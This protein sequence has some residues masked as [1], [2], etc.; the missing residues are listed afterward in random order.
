MLVE[1]VDITENSE[2]KIEKAARLCYDSKEN[3]SV[4]AGFIQRLIN[5]GHL[6]VIEHAKATFL[7]TGVSRAFSH[8]LVRHRIASYSQRSQRFCDESNINADH[9]VPDSILNNDLAR[10]EYTNLT[11]LSRNTYRRLVSL[12]IPKEDARFV[13]TNGTTTKIMITM[14][15]RTLREFIQKRGK[16]NAQWEIRKVAAL[17]LNHLK[18]HAPNVFGDLKVEGG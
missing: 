6:S 10:I 3:K 17:M 16:K 1:L 12:G 18:R 8:Q 15:F 5:A 11:R 13:L 4:R 2:E 7:V 14:N 9:I